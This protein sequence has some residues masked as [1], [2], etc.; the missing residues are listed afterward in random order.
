MSEEKKRICPTCSTVIPARFPE[1]LCPKCL[2]VAANGEPAPIPPTGWS[3]SGQSSAREPRHSETTEYGGGDAKPL[4]KPGDVIGRYRLV[5][6]LG[7]GGF[8]MV[9][10]AEQRE[11]IRRE[12]ALKIIKP[13]MDSMAILARFVAERQTLA[14]M[15]HPNIAMVLDAGATEAG[16]PF[17]VMELVH[18]EPLTVYCDARKLSVRNR[19]EL[20]L[21]VC[22][23][24][25]HAHQKAVLHRDLKPS[26]ILV[27][28]VD[29]RPAP[30]VIDF[31]I[32]KALA[33]TEETVSLLRTREDILIGT[34]QYMS[35]EQAGAG[36]V[37]VDT[38]SDVYALGAVLYELLTGAPLVDAAG[39]RR[40]GLE[41]LLRRIREEEPRKPSSRLLPAT[42]SSR[43]VSLA[44]GSDPNRLTV[45]L[46]GDL[47]WITLKALEK[48]RERRYQTAAALAED[49]QRH[50]RDEPVEA[51]PP[52]ATYRL[53]KLVKK[54]RGLFA[55]LGAVFFC[56]LAGL[57]LS[58]YAFLR[59][60][61]ALQ[62]EASQ[63]QE[64]IA[65]REEAEQQRQIATLTRDFVLG[66]FREID[67]GNSRGREVTVRSMLDKAADNLGSSLQ[68][69]P[70][71]ELEIR[72]LFWSLYRDLGQPQKALEHAQAALKLTPADSPEWAHANNSVAQ[73]WHILGQHEKA[74]AHFQTALRE[75][76]RWRQGD[77][78]HA[79]RALVGIGVTLCAL[80][81]PE[82]GLAQLQA[83]LEMRRSLL[84]G[85]HR[86]VAFAINNVGY[87]LSALGRH[88]E[89]LA[90]YQAAL[91]MKQRLFKGNHPDVAVSLYNVASAQKKL[92]QMEEA[93]VNFQAVLEMERVLYGEDHRFVASC[94]NELAVCLLTMDRHEEAL[95]KQQAALAIWQRTLPADH[96]DVILAH[97][98]L[99]DCLEAL[100]RP[101][102]ARTHYLAAG[103]LL[104]GKGQEAA[105]TITEILPGGQA[106]RL[107]LQAG[108]VLAQYGTSAV[109][110]PFQL[111]LLCQQATGT[112][113]N[114]GLRRG[115]Q[116]IELAA[117]GGE[118][119]AKVTLQTLPLA[120]PP[121]AAPATQEPKPLAYGGS[122]YRLV[123][124][125]FTWEQART[126]A[127]ALSGHLAEITTQG[128]ERA[129]RD[130][131]RTQPE[132][133]TG[134]FWLG[135]F[136]AQDEPAPRWI[137]GE[138]VP[139][140]RLWRRGHPGWRKEAGSRDAQRFGL[141]CP[142]GVACSSIEADGSWLIVRPADKTQFGFLLEFPDPAHPGIAPKTWEVGDSLDEAGGEAVRLPV[143]EEPKDDQAPD[144]ANR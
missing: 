23:A 88:E 108:D 140:T 76:R 98:N 99:G 56:L 120:E 43:T 50:L 105:V 11:P 126:E 22:Q 94:L 122:R 12:V 70:T 3:A 87:G 31:G 97:R 79:A 128:E 96:D 14:R 73:G 89:A 28:E 130:F 17:F 137:S 127:E 103:G 91:E 106:E 44:R 71:A 18:G 110:S 53:L 74:L 77:D 6:I 13:G 39:L 40:A 114:L 72:K 102:E 101:D 93:A 78:H 86:E 81:R 54:K 109:F 7:E 37:D 133:A 5:E 107:G 65:K 36:K 59:E 57:G 10:R 62:R 30:K 80:G 15:E 125:K 141:L 136:A 82:E 111:V 84:K 8:G 68:N 35:P 142:A 144:A 27:T 60:Q 48:D 95:P 45:A 52:N 132:Q 66:M 123:K 100:D 19:L 116:R 34:P 67:P 135:G 42:E 63:R 104:R 24:V 4:E 64:A 75:A 115:N 124:G 9:W 119:A 69:A 121:P 46:R 25:Q 47:D 113:V 112:P 61:R 20:F 138:P 26:N 85:D 58:T 143:Q 117:P 32:A 29:G 131:I 83:G 92:G 33:E 51:S 118:L 38:R 16:R 2:L 1:G 21:P 129:V 134:G 55:S 139:P 41:D 90:S 49:I